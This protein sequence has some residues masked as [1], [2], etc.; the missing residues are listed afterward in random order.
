MTKGI[1]ILQTGDL[2]IGKGRSSWTNDGYNLSIKRASKLFDTLYDVAE[3]YGC[4]AILITGDVFD[5]KKVTDA[6]RELVSRKLAEHSSRVPTYVIPGNHDQITEKKTSNLDFLSEI[7]EHTDEIPSLHISRT[8]VHSVWEL[9]PG[10]KIVGAPAP[11]S[12]DQE[13]VTNW[14]KGLDDRDSQYIFMGHGTV[15]YCSRNDSG[16]QPPESEDHG[17]SLR[18]AAEA[19]PEVIWWAY[20]DIHKRQ[21]LPTLPEGANG[22]YAG[23]PIQM[24]FGETED[25]GVYI[26]KFKND[27]DWKYSGKKYVRID[28][29]GFIPLVT[30]K[31]QDQLD[32]LPEDALLKLD[33]TVRMP[34]QRKAQV[35]S[36][37]KVVEDLSPPVVDDEDIDEDEEVRIEL[38]YFDPILATKEE[39]EEETLGGMEDHLKEEGRKVVSEATSTYRHR[40]FSG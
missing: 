33:K 25:R 14:A 24:N 16:W 20:G 36:K 11:L 15:K 31:S 19:A 29:R 37:F 2:H 5:V 9:K 21:K 30:V 3:E 13:W 6:E 4:D 32:D 34:T 12:E 27:G 17:L 40:Y 28:N 23:S 18:E 10:L 35:V 22:A 38:S 7:T 26:L 39:I 8:D 1:K